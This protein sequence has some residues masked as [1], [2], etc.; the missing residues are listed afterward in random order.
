M[1]KRERLDSLRQFCCGQSYKSW[2]DGFCG[3]HDHLDAS[4]EIH[5][6]SFVTSSALCFRGSNRWYLEYT[7]L[8]ASGTFFSST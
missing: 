4:L 7:T 2:K 6:S 8:T 1:I 5:F 3:S